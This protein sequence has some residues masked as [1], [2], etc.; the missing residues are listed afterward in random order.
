MYNVYDERTRQKNLAA[1]PV[2]RVRLAPIVRDSYDEI[3][4]LRQGGETW[5]D[6]ARRL[7]NLHDRDVDA[8]KAGRAVAKAFAR[9]RQRRSWTTPQQTSPASDCSRSSSPRKGAAWGT[10]GKLNLTPSEPF[11]G[12]RDD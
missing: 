8:T 3:A 1:A 11:F 9:E 12:G 6:I 7:V 2:R 5:P 4:R 10:G